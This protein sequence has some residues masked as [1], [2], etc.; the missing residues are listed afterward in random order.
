MGTYSGPLGKPESTM[1]FALTPEREQQV[2]D[3]ITRYPQVWVIEVIALL[4]LLW[5][6]VRWRLYRWAELKQF[7]LTGRLG[8]S[9][10]GDF[11]ADGAYPSLPQEPEGQRPGK[12]WAQSSGAI[13]FVQGDTPQG[14]AII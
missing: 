11:K 12:T 2:D 1:A 5:F 7:V 9:K 8:R 10:S 14:H 6:A 13:H 4:Y 3:I